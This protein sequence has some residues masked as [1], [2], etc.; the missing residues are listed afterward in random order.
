MLII[1]TH[2]PNIFFYLITFLFHI[3]RRR[4]RKS[5]LLAKKPIKKPSACRYGDNVMVDR[6]AECNA[7]LEQYDDDVIGYCIVVLAT[8]IHREPSLATPLLLEML[9]CVSR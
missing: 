9:Q 3:A 7:I 4:N 1:L 6:C 2:C 8:F 5:E